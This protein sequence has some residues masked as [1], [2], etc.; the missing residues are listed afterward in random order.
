MTHVLG[1]ESEVGRLRQAVV[2]RPGL[3]LTRLTPSNCD[4]LLFDD[5]LWAEKAREEHDVFAQ[6]LRNQG[7]TVH[8]F[9]RT[10]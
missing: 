8:H 10:A 6:E 9:G 3:E 5:V 1:V 4:E 2:H 7:V